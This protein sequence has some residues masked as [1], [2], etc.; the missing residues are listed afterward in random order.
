MKYFHSKSWHFPTNQ[1]TD[2]TKGS[3]EEYLLDKSRIIMTEPSRT[4]HIRCDVGAGSAR[5]RW[6]FDDLDS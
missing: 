4:K 5:L 1:K 3:S 2:Y 6:P